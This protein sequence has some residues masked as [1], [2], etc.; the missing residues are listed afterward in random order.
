VPP[1]L[2]RFWAEGV[3]AAEDV[4]FHEFET[5]ETK[6]AMA[7]RRPLRPFKRPFWLRFTYVASV[8]VKKY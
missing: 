5:I 4:Q 1:Q 6:P 7:V 3:I 8:L 2:K